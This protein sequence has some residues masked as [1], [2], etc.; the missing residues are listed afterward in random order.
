MEPCVVP[1]RTPFPSHGWAVVRREGRWPERHGLCFAATTVA[2]TRRG[3]KARAEKEEEEEE[4]E[5]VD[6]ERLALSL[7]DEL[8]D[9]VPVVGPL[10]N[11]KEAWFC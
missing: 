4:E 3:L 1:W 2:A 5:E 7:A 9:F 6:Y 8:L 11:A 10:R